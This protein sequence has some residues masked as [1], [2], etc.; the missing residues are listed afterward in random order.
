MNFEKKSYD[1]YELLPFLYPAT[2]KS[3]G[4][5]VTPSIQIFVLECPGQH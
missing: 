1:I 2:L 3:V 4:Y 5:Y